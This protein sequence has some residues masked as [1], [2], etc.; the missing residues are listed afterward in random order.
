[1]KEEV[2]RRRDDNGK[3]DNEGCKSCMYCTVPLKVLIMPSLRA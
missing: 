1:M 2:K 3:L